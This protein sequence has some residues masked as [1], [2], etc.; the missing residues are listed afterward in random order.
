VL[1]TTAGDVAV[2]YGLLHSRTPQGRYAVRCERYAARRGWPKPERWVGVD[3]DDP[4]AEPLT[5]AQSRA[6]IA[7]AG[8]DRLLACRDPLLASTDTA[9]TRPPVAQQEPLSW[10]A[11][12]ACQGSDPGLFDPPDASLR[13][14]HARGR[15]GRAAAV[16]ASCPVATRCLVEALK[17]HDVGVR[18]G[19]LLV[20]R[21]PSSVQLTCRTIQS[22]GT[23]RTAA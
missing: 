18:G 7:E 4:A 20:R 3:L 10:R 13:S 16:C 1:A 11:L 15:L 8:I 14:N 17:D 9:A 22:R 12:A 6:A 23:R 2:L 5:E 21:N 19:V